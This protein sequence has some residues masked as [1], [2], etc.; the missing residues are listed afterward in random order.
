MT[1]KRFSNHGFTLAELV[2]VMGILIVIFALLMGPTSKLVKFLRDLETQRK[3]DALQSGVETIYKANAWSIDSSN[4]NALNFSVNGVAYSLS[5]GT[6]DAGGNLTAMQALA[7]VA[8]L[9]SNDITLDSMHQTFWVGVS[10]YLNDPT[11]GIYYH[12]IAVIS[13][14]WDGTLNSSFDPATGFLS[15]KGDDMGFVVSGFQYQYANLED[16]KKSSTQ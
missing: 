7:P 16:A 5:T 3:L 13:P 8:G 11:T 12:T 4:G 1:R 10:N 14:G 9:A 6:S 15:L 2:I